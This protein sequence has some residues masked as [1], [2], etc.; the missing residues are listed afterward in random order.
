M[1]ALRPAEPSPPAIGAAS[2]SCRWQDWIEGAKKEPAQK[3]CFWHA[4]QQLTADV[5]FTTRLLAMG[6]PSS[7]W[8]TTRSK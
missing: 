1:V 2:V 5:V 3:G 4:M 8:K 7:G 6:K